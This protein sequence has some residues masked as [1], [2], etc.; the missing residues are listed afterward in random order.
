MGELV[1]QSILA[2]TAGILL[3]LTPCVL[4]AIPLK[5]RAI[6]NETGENTRTRLCAAGAFLTGSLGFFLLLGGMTAFFHQNWGFLFQSD[7][8]LT[9][10]VLFLAVAGVLTFFDLRLP[11]PQRLYRIRGRRYLEPLLT[12]ALTG[13]LSTPCTGPFLGGV[14][15]FALTRPPAMILWFFALIG[16]GLAL[17][18][19]IFILSPGLLNRL[20]QGGEWTLRLK[21]VLG[22]VLLAGAV[23][24]AQSLLSPP[25][26]GYAWVLWAAALALWGIVS[27]VKSATW[28]AR[29]IPLPFALLGV[30]LV[31]TTLTAPSEASLPWQPYTVEA[32]KEARLSHRPVLIE[33]TADW[34]INC[35]VLEKTVYSNAEVL[36]AAGRMPLSALRVDLT[37]PQESLQRLLASYGGAGL[38]FAVVLD[39]RGRIAERLPDLFTPGALVEALRKAQMRKDSDE[40]R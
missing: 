7:L 27:L 1:G 25:W 13:I 12:G 22:F 28:S 4:P 15:A 8:F 40:N 5:I 9:F 31:H 39:S 6:L 19:L 14:L 3:N 18:Y 26:T 29:L 2:V 36:N 24:F 21:E 16:F 38:P 20:P 32:L 30:L 10:L 33:F 23:F 34:C 37:D 11:L 35:K 17:P